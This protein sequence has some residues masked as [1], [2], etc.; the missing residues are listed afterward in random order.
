MEMSMPARPYIRRV[1][2]PVL[3]FIFQESGYA[4][5]NSW[6]GLS[7]LFSSLPLC[8]DL[9]SGPQTMRSWAS[10][11][12]RDSPSPQS[13]TDS[14]QSLGPEGEGEGGRER[15]KESKKNWCV[16]W[17]YGNGKWLWGMRI[18]IRGCMIQVPALLSPLTEL[19]ADLLCCEWCSSMRWKADDDSSTKGRTV[20]IKGN[21]GLWM[22]W[23]IISLIK[24]IAEICLFP[25]CFFRNG[26]ASSLWRCL[27][28]KWCQ[29][30]A[31]S[32]NL[33]PGP[34]R[35]WPLMLWH[36]CKLYLALA[37]EWPSGKSGG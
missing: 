34:A 24:I 29:T 11:S 8:K 22:V 20:R 12:E 19:W 35:G 13:A 26:F 2:W 27:R 36:L 6:P 1:W 30:V 23:E 25:I 17:E 28:W 10:S 18:G 3:C 15:S 16:L 21:D 9:P 4:L 32:K 7:C 14:V 5:E 31:K 33:D 37:S